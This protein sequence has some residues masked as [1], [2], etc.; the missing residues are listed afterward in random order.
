M[1]GLRGS[2]ISNL[3][4]VNT[5]DY[6]SDDVNSMYLAASFIAL[7]VWAWVLGFNAG[8]GV[9][10]G[11]LGVSGAYLFF[12]HAINAISK[13]LF[14]YD[15]REAINF[16]GNVTRELF[17]SLLL[18]LGATFT[19]WLWG[20]GTP[21]FPAMSD[22]VYFFLTFPAGVLIKLLLTM[23]E[24]HHWIGIGIA[25]AILCGLGYVFS[26]GLI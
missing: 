22:F 5:D 9:I 8:M 19:L 4:D 7:A 23:F 26:L 15:V 21:P 17:I 16:K 25:T 18:L 11:L 3:T 12:L 2:Q 20:S 14:D 24:E 13:T 6:E 10:A 1:F